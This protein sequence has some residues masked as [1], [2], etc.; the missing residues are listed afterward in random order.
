MEKMFSVVEIFNND[1]R[2]DEFLRRDVKNA[3]ETAFQSLGLITRQ[4]YSQLSTH[5]SRNAT[6]QKPHI[7][8][9]GLPK[10]NGVKST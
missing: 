3:S 10:S 8:F 7:P 6:S 5:S 2:R 1:E 9:L 4:Q